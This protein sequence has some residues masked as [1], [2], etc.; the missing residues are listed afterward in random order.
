MAKTASTRC[1]EC[2][3][4][5]EHFMTGDKCH[6]CVNNSLVSASD[7][8]DCD[9][10][11]DESVMGSELASD[12]EVEVECES[13]SEDDAD[14][15]Q[16]KQES[17][18]NSKKPK[19]VIDIDAPEPLVSRTVTFAKPSRPVGQKSS[20]SSA[21]SSSAPKSAQSDKSVACDNKPPSKK[22]GASKSAGESTDAPAKKRAKKTPAEVEETKVSKARV[23]VETI[24]SGNATEIPKEMLM[25][26]V[27]VED[28]LRSVFKDNQDLYRATLESLGMF[29][30]NGELT[31]DFHVR[32]FG[33]DADRKK[34]DAHFKDRV[35]ELYKNIAPF[36]PHRAAKKTKA[37]LYLET[38]DFATF[39][40]MYKQRAAEQ[41]LVTK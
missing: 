12:E 22:R 16:S 39:D 3:V 10:C 35:K 37:E 4:R 11:E 19:E 40:R 28:V 2:N 18:T 25:V 6:Q 15:E 23:A 36:A 32:F 7:A 41:K 29:G 5:V 38:V 27:E 26:A 20:D 33:E 9:E 14:E 31:R 1:V 17:I 21:S 8:S 24:L 34:M 30:Q 13:E